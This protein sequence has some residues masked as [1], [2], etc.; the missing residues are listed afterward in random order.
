MTLKKLKNPV[1]RK[2]FAIN[3]IE[4]FNNKLTLENKRFRVDFDEDTY[5]Y[6]IRLDRDSFKKQRSISHDNKIRLN[7]LCNEKCQLNQAIKENTNAKKLKM[8]QIVIHKYFN[9]PVYEIT[10]RDIFNKSHAHI[11]F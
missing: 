1:L 11:L 7:E 8:I 5:K 6:F 10:V 4:E 3:A 2:H 9:Y